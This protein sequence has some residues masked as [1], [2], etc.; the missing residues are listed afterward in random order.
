MK[1]TKFQEC[2]LTKNNSNDKHFWFN[3][4]LKSQLL[5]TYHISI[6]P[7]SSYRSSI[8]PSPDLLIGPIMINLPK[9]VRWPLFSITLVSIVCCILSSNHGYFMPFSGYWFLSWWWWPGQATILRPWRWYASWSTFHFIC[10]WCISTWAISSHGSSVRRT[11]WHMCCF[12]YW[13]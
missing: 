3:V 5:Q 7:F 6:Q 1:T 9:F 13:W 4:N 11:L 10:W 8:L 12:S 2:W